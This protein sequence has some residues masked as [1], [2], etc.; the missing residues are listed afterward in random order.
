LHSVPFAAETGYTNAAYP[1]VEASAK[2]Q[3]TL[4]VAAS[5]IA[6]SFHLS[7]FPTFARP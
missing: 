3:S 5:S 1:T 6:A 7:Y 2:P 4:T